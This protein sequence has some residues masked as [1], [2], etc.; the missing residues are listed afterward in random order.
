MF[1]KMALQDALSDLAESE[2]YENNRHG[3][4]KKSNEMYK[5][6]LDVLRELKG[7]ISKIK[8]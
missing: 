8:C 2:K 6:C 4:I 7:K 1:L 3:Y 5:A